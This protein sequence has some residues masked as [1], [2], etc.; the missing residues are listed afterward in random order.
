MNRVNSRNG[1]RHGNG[2]INKVVV[3]IKLTILLVQLS[4][5]PFKLFET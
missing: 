2:T 4:Q 3:I 5:G 1:Y